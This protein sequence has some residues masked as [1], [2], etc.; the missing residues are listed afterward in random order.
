MSFDASAREGVVG[1][2]TMGTGIGQ[3]A[4]TYGHPVVVCDT[5]ARQLERAEDSLGRILS[6]LAKK[7]KLDPAE[8]R[9]IGARIHFTS[10]LE[11]LEDSA[12]VIEAIVED[13][14]LKQAA[15][16]RIEQLVSEDSS[17]QPTLPPFPSPASRP[18]CGGRSDCWRLI[19]SIQRPSCRWSSSFPPA[20]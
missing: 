15:F 4:A 1:A 13:M 14:G 2:G 9:D 20:Y 12:F 18:R 7:G 11:S 3:I 16:R 17:W 8:A 10:N 6:R 19:S 5:S